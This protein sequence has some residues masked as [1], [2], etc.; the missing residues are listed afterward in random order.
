MVRRTDH[1]RC[2]RRQL[3]RWSQLSSRTPNANDPAERVEAGS[4]S[5]IPVAGET[6]S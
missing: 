4:F 5:V 2:V 6:P 3:S 1:I